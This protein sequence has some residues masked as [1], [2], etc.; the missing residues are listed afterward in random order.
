MS[1]EVY[2]RKQSM[3]RSS[4]LAPI[5]EF[6]I[7]VII[8]ESLLRILHFVYYFLFGQSHAHG[9]NTIGYVDPNI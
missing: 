5:L 4:S 1:V 2:A 6:G 7:P 9:I 3:T 8:L